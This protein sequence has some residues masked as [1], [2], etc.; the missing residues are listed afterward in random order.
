MSSTA[1]AGI[2]SWS[3]IGAG[4][5]IVRTAFTAS[6]SAWGAEDGGIGPIEVT[7]KG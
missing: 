3:G 2:C 4:T 6:G 1:G 7:A 5:G